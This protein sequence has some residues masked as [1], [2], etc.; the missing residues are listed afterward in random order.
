MDPRSRVSLE[1]YDLAAESHGT[2]SHR[3]APFVVI[4]YRFPRDKYD[5]HCVEEDCP[6]GFF[7]FVGWAVRS[8]DDFNLVVSSKACNLWVKVT[9]V[10]VV[11]L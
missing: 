9:D 8:S 7:S 10:R 5:V 4:L 11:S 1:F 3:Q 2:L 6:E